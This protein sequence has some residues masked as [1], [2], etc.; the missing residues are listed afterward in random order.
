MKLHHIQV[1]SNLLV[2]PKFV[3]DLM[4]C[5]VVF[6]ANL[7]PVAGRDCFEVPKS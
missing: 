1:H 3:Q 2:Y 7:H 6:Q 5:P 4:D